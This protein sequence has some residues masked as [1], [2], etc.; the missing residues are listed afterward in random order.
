MQ[1][2]FRIFRGFD[3]D[4]PAYAYHIALKMCF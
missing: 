1:H 2:L 3:F 4:I